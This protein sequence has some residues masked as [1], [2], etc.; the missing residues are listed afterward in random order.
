M[1]RDYTT[2]DNVAPH[3]DSTRVPVGL[4]VIL[5]CSSFSQVRPSDASLI[6]PGSGTGNYEIALAKFFKSVLG[7]D[8]SQE[9]LKKAK[10]KSKAIDNI[11]FIRGDAIEMKMF[12]DNMFDVA[13]FNH[14]LHHVG[15]YEHQS[16]ALQESYR[17][18][19]DKGVIIIQTCS[20]K[21]LRD[22]FWYFDLIPEATER[23]TKK[24]MPVDEL[25]D[26]LKNIGFEYKG[27]IVPVDAI[28][29]G[30]HYLDVEGPLKEEW[31]SGDSIWS[32]VTEAELDKSQ[33][34]IRE[35]QANGTIDDY[36]YKREALR[37]DIGQV[38]FV[39]AMK[40][41]MSPNIEA[42]ESK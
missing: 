13:M 22:G 19:K 32:L 31:R 41:I 26:T 11:E 28:I 33:Q 21:Q 2:Y 4:D 23:Q 1:N 12:A 18:L 30:E 24:L 25:S 15:D 29:M 14:S 9:M 16:K 8:I 6:S 40:N 27:S 10:E 36:I 39:Y 34:I 3:Y 37:K 35:M 20:Q 42:Q 38:T 17:I 7:V 5:G